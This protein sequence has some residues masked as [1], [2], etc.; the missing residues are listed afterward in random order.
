MS[1]VLITTVPFG[2]IIKTPFELLNAAGIDYVLNPLNKKLTPNELIQLI[3]EFDVV[4][5][6]TEIIN[7][8]V[9]DS[10]A[11]LKFI[12]RVGIGLD[13]LD[14]ETIKK[15]G[16][17]LSYTA[18]APAAAVAELTIGLM[19][20]L[21]RNIH[22]SNKSMHE[23][24]WH[25]YF[26][27]RIGTST[28]G[29]I[30]AG[31]IGKKV[32]RHLDSFNPPRVL[33]NDLVVDKNISG[34]LNIEWVDVEK[35]FRESDLIS[36]HI[37]LNNTTKN[38]IDKELLF[39]MKKGSSIINTSRGG[40]INEQDL[41]N[42]LL[43]GHL[44]SAAIDVFEEEPYNGPLNNLDNCVLTAHMGSM[45]I[46]CRARMEIEAT[47]EAIRFIKGEN[48]LCEVPCYEYGEK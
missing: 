13:S 48:L 2:E 1:I 17:K 39:S 22:L 10:A 38:L 41:Y 16:I 6:G 3:P 14:L 28:I 47:Q 5:A 46:D 18:D 27:N 20:T 35:I 15:K 34:N 23:G 36:L 29:I 30:G 42:V 33:V 43:S 21:L 45:S 12:S 32:L 19:L 31:R 24:K 37:P 8:Q 25:R 44:A 9:L 7:S 40:I 26:G 4:I 11:K